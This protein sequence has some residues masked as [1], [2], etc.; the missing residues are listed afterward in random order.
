MAAGALFSRLRGV[1]L[2]AALL[3]VGLGR[4]LL[5]GALGLAHGQAP[6][7]PAPAP[8]APAPDYRA[9]LGARLGAQIEALS[10]TN[11]EAAGTLGA[12]IED[13]VGPLAEARYATGLA[14]NRARDRDTALVW[15]DRC[16]ALAPLHRGAL[17]DRAELRLLGG[18]T[19]GARADLGLLLAHPPVHWSTQLRVAQLAAMDGDPLAFERAMVGALAAGFE[20]RTLALDPAWRAWLDDPALGP[21]LH[22]LI[23]VYGSEGLLDELRSQP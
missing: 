2:F 7:S 13:R 5:G 20:L 17:Y 16:L 4:S 11:P 9:E 10:A 8:A 19:E 14:F 21:I 1:L 22:R 3:S 18:D 6:A 12:R 23:A 15:Y